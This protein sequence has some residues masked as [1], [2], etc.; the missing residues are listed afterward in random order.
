[1]G[2]SL[3]VHQEYYRQMSTVIE[4]GKIAKL[5]ILAD[6]GAPGNYAGKRLQD[7]NYEGHY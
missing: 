6:S 4:C 1:M 2:H 5:L 3:N 7:I